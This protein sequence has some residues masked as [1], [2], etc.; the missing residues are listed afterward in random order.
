VTEVEVKLVD[1]DAAESRL[2]DLKAETE[3]VGIDFMKKC[4][5]NP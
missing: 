1:V 3:A 2:R 4:R 5:F